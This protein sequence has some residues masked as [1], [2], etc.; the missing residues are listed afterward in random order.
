MVV[1]QV[2]Q[3]WPKNVGHHLWTSLKAFVEALNYDQEV[4]TTITEKLNGKLP[5]VKANFGNIIVAKVIHQ[6]KYIIQIPK[7]STY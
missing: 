4:V 1:T 3:I 6:Y 2:G 5:I 7:L